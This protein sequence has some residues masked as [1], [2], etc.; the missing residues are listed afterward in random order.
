MKVFRTGKDDLPHP[1]F[2]GE[3]RKKTTIRAVR[4][5]KDFAVLT[6]EGMVKGKAGDWLAKGVKGELYPI[7]ADVFD[8]TYELALR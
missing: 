4:M 3:Y 8:R 5:E 6:L 2:A 7:A 1:E